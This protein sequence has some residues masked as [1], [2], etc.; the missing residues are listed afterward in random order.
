MPKLS[1]TIKR[2]AE[3][4][5]EIRDADKLTKRHKKWLVDL[6]RDFQA[7]AVDPNARIMMAFDEKTEW[8]T[9]EETQRFVFLVRGFGFCIGSTGH[10]DDELPPD[11]MSLVYNI[12]KGNI[13]HLKFQLPDE[14]GNPLRQ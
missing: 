14:S 10:P 6:W 2:Y 11:L 5:D 13:P 9:P 4:L 8:L 3:V 1:H 12:V 7:H